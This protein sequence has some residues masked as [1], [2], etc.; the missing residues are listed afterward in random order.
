[1]EGARVLYGRLM[2]KEE[3]FRYHGRVVRQNGRVVLQYWFFY[4]FND[5]RSNFFGAN[6]HEA[7]W[8]KVFVYLSESEAGEMCPE[9]VAY[10]AHAES[11]DDLRR[12]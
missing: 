1:V 2:E 9:W 10:A 6:D 4:A 5:W 3:R 8:E 7:D 12:R 11:G